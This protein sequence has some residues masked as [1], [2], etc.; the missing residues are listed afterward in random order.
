[1]AIYFVIKQITVLHFVKNFKRDI[2]LAYFCIT[3]C[4]NGQYNLHLEY[5]NDYMYCE[6]RWVLDRE[7]LVCVNLIINCFSWNSLMNYLIVQ[8]LWLL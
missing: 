3:I 5:I 7:T 1:M 6:K 2:F 8:K 4:L